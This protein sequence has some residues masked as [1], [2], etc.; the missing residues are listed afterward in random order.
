MKRDL[1]KHLHHIN[2]SSKCLQYTCGHRGYV[3][4]PISKGKKCIFFPG[5]HYSRGKGGGP[6]LVRPL[7]HYLLLFMFKI[8]FVN[9]TIGFF[10]FVSKYYICISLSFKQEL[11]FLIFYLVKKITQSLY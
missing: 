8:F 10:R 9:M 6:L 1:I 2:N 7:K 11:L 5:G 4:L 3:V